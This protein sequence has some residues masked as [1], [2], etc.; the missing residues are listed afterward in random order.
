MINHPTYKDKKSAQATIRLARNKFLAIITGTANTGSDAAAPT[1]APA[2]KKKATPAKRKKATVE[3]DGAAA[4]EA[5]PAKK[6][7]A[8][9]GRKTLARAPVAPA[10]APADAEPKDS[11]DNQVADVD[12]LGD[13]GRGGDSVAGLVVADGSVLM[14]GLA[15][16]WVWVF[17]VLCFGL[18]VFVF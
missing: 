2:P 11:N 6:I 13:E 3:D 12:L 10:S 18:F 17:C 16:P 7:P 4:A 5:G 1:A 9:R 14:G 8:K 15:D